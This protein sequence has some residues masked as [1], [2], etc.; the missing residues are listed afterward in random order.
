[1]AKKHKDKTMAA[2]AGTGTTHKSGKPA[3][4]ARANA[5]NSD[6]ATQA[7]PSV[8]LENLSDEQ[9]LDFLYERNLDLIK[10]AREAADKDPIG[11]QR[12][13]C[14][15]VLGTRM[16]DNPF[17]ETRKAA[18][19]NQHDEK[20]PRR[21]LHA[22]I[23]ELLLDRFDFVERKGAD[24]RPPDPIS[25]RT[26]MIESCYLDSTFFS[27]MLGRNYTRPPTLRAALD[28]LGLP[29]EYL[30][31]QE[32]TFRS[33]LFMACD[34]IYHGVPLFR[35]S[36]REPEQF[37]QVSYRDEDYIYLSKM[38]QHGVPSDYNLPYWATEFYVYREHY[39]AQEL[40]FSQA[41]GVKP[42]EVP[43]LRKALRTHIGFPDAES[44]VEDRMSVALR[45]A[46][47]LARRDV[48]ELF[49]DGVW[50]GHKR[51]VGWI[52][53]NVPGCESD[54]R[55]EAIAIVAAPD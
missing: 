3:P 32:S 35:R 19:P 51:V 49:R 41:N 17:D 8:D 25:I 52:Q 23:A 40:F 27:F 21:H 43:L 18:T 37:V 12:L 28:G 2:T 38:G 50:P 10:K 44:P 30:T 5:T 33:A 39:E 36:A 42:H 11:I 4:K 53:E 24:P 20:T 15:A 22:D 47:K 55:A 34:F 7:T 1:V 6:G 26:W 45:T 9:M 14:Q 54:R 13:L 29:D 46:A 31:S 16:D 48:P